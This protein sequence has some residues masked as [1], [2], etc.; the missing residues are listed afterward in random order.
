MRPFGT[1][2]VM[3]CMGWIC[4]TSPITIAVEPV[5]DI[6][7]TEPV[8]TEAVETAKSPETVAVDVPNDS[9]AEVQTLEPILPSNFVGKEMLRREQTRRIGEAQNRWRQVYDTLTTPEAIAAYQARQRTFF[10]AAVG[11]FPSPLTDDPAV[12]AARSP[13]NAQIVETLTRTGVADDGSTYSYRVEKVIFE[14]QPNHYVTAA[15]F[16]PDASRFPA[17]WPGVVVACGHS[18]D[19]K[20]YSGYQT[21]CALAAIHGIAAIIFDPI[22]QGERHQLLTDE[23]KPRLDGTGAHNMVGVG[24]MLLGRNTARY[25]IWDG[26]RT[27]DYLQ[28]RGDIRAD[29]IGCM[30]NSGGG[31]QTSYLMALDPRIVAAA[32]SCYL[33]SLYGLACNKEGPQDAEQNILSQLGFGM[34]HV[35]YVLM[36]APRPTLLC[37]ATQDFFP[38]DMAWITFRDAKRIYGRFGLAHRIDLVEM[39]QPHGWTPRLREA[40]VRWMLRWLTEQDV[41]IV[42][43]ASLEKSTL[44]ETEIRC[45]PTGE[46]MRL[47]E[48]KSVYDLNR[49]YAAQLA[50]ERNE[51][52]KNAPPEEL[53]EEIRKLVGVRS[54]DTIPE[55]TVTELTPVR[56]RDA[57][58]QPVVLTLENDQRIPLYLISSDRIG[59]FSTNDS[60]DVSSTIDEATSTAKSDACW[61]LYLHEG[62][63]AAAMA[64]DSPLWQEV[65]MGRTVVVPD[66]RGLGETQQSG[67]TYFNPKLHGG[68]GQDFYRTYLLGGNYV[69][70]RTEDIWTITRW[71]QRRWLDATESSSVSASSSQAELSQATLSVATSSE[72]SQTSDKLPLVR[73]ISVGMCQIPA[74]H[75]ATLEPTL[76]YAGFV[77]LQASAHGMES[78]EQEPPIS[79]HTVVEQGFVEFPLTGLVPGSL[80]VYDL[81]QLW[82]WLPQND[83]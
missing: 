41:E 4:G 56:Y 63:K 62:G 11:D 6:A 13:L 15:I 33:C 24:S 65:E 22:D 75:A 32:P 54:L 29:R 70:M 17:P 47:A 10:T 48:A 83:E 74:L 50:E 30:G 71:M 26:V 2:C 16:L 8:A 53:R 42:E 51:R 23:G 49:E 43:P 52:W 34:D 77:S 69:A 73:L 31:T 76:R 67:Q 78:S 44:S 68:D 21:G 25:E 61:T 60:S 59:S 57:F 27:I 46:V 14:S 1:L 80:R 72:S 7:T 79:W 66:L 37:T 19:G 40:S 28:S 36:R 5:A 9:V 81:P 35:D 20:A 82:Q 45:T 39:D 64:Q 12:I 55:P 18:S 58:V 38:I 3:L